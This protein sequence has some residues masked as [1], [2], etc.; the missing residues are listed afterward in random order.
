MLR[1][2][3]F[4]CNKERMGART[5]FYFYLAMV[6]VLMASFLGNSY[7]SSEFTISVM[8]KNDLPLSSHVYLTFERIFLDMEVPTSYYSPRGII[9]VGNKI[10]RKNI[11]PGSHHKVQLSCSKGKGTYFLTGI[12]FARFSSGF[13]ACGPKVQINVLN[14]DR[15]LHY[16]YSL[17]RSGNG[18]YFC[19]LI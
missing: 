10:E 7:V 3:N 4:Y 17:Q 19:S 14:N 16:N 9:H 8:F 15:I 6:F 13:R 2:D 18:E 1:K 12:G 5:P 11:Y